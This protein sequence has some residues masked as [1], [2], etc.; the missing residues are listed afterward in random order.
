MLLRLC[1]LFELMQQNMVN[2][3]TYFGYEFDYKFTVLDEFLYKFYI[4]YFF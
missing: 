2:V 1:C 4:D 3:I